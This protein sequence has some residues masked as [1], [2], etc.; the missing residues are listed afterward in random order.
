[1][2]F[3]EKCPK[4]G[5]IEE[6]NWRPIFGPNS[7]VYTMDVVE[8]E[9]AQDII[10]GHKPSEVWTDNAWAYHFRKTAQYLERIPLTVYRA[11]GRWPGHRYGSTIG[12]TRRGA[13]FKRDFLRNMKLKRIDQAKLS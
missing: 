8:S 2:H 9:N 3:L 11:E 4:C 10:G 1:M 5:H 13:E 7:L 6:H 12:T